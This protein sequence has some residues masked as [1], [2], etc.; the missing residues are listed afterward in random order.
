MQFVFATTAFLSALLLFAVQPLIGKWLHPWFGATPALWTAMLFFFQFVLLLGYTYSD[1]IVMR[2]KIQR[3]VILH[4]LV[5]SAATLVLFVQSFFWHKPI[6]PDSSW[7]PLNSQMPLLH[8]FLI[9]IVSVGLPFLVLSTTS[10][11]LQAW[12]NAVHP[13]RSP[14]WLYSFSNAGSLLGLLL[15]PLLLEP[16]FAMRRQAI[17]WTVGFVFYVILCLWCAKYI[18][19][20]CKNAHSNVVLEKTSGRETIKPYAWLLWLLCACVPTLLLLATTTKIMEEVASFPLLW[21]FPLM[22]YLITFILCFGG[23]RYSRRLFVPLVLAGIAVTIFIMRKPPGTIEAI[24]QVATLLISLFFCC[25]VCHG[26][27]YRL[28]PPPAYLTRY[29]LCIAIGGALGGLFGSVV[30][31]IIFTE[32]WELEIAY[33]GCVFL[34]VILVS[35]DA[36]SVKQRRW[37][38]TWQIAAVAILL[39]AAVILFVPKSVNPGARVIRK[40]R[41]FYGTLSVE[42][43]IMSGS[44]KVRIQYNGRTIHGLQLVE[45]KYQRMPACYYTPNSGVGLILQNHPKRLAKQDRKPLRVGAVGLGVGT[46]AAYAQSGDYF[47]FY[48]INPAVVKQAQGPDSC[49]TYLKLCRGEYDIIMGDG[50]I[51]LENELLLGKEQNFDVLVLDAFSGDMI[52]VHLIT[53]QAFKIYLKH[54]SPDGVIAFHTSNRN[55]LLAPVIFKIAEELGLEAVMIKT[56]FESDTAAEPATWVLL[57][58]TK[59]PISNAKIIKSSLKPRPDAYAKA[60]LWT[61][62]FNNPLKMLMFRKRTLFFNGSSWQ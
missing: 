3:Q 31:P 49:F 22:L 30:A 2:L 40:D 42:E 45:Q 46:I 48:E 23:F 17:V 57:S 51:A 4:V 62:D 35:N 53:L 44:T 38:H 56:G 33:L 20:V 14:Y 19:G 34:P 47:R 59:Q 39:F 32:V 10:S 61:D 54:L 8:I 7:R 43:L 41:N 27:L 21:I 16:L 15:Y 26:E 12:F 24:W 18:Q 29:Y 58:L 25:M 52:P 55:F 5:L 28:R 13:G 1:L 9:L 50:R 6:L 11:L 60:P 37:Y 36:K